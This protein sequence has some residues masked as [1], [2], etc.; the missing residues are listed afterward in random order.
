MA[1]RAT[2]PAWTAAASWR[3]RWPAARAMSVGLQFFEVRTQDDFEPA[4][5]TV[6]RERLGGVLVFGEVIGLTTFG[7]IVALA[8]RHRVP[9]MSTVRTF[10][11][12]G[13]VM[14][15]GPSLV[16]SYRRAAAHV[17]KIL[18]GAKPGD[19][20]I[21]QPTKFELVINLK[22]ARALGLTVPRSLLAQADQ[23]I[24]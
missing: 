6:S 14:S 22:A 5:V 8:T 20:A 4:F 17:D 23:V 7:H 18:K 10:P 3:P 19:L 13:G 1:I 21:E 16:D 24:E 9:S 11:D 12:A 15:D 2:I